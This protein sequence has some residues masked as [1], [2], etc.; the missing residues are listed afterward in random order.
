MSLPVTEGT[1]YRIAVD[2]FD[3]AM[4]NITL[5]TGVPGA[6]VANAGPDASAAA[7]AAFFLDARNSTDPQ[8]NPL[9]F[10]WTRLSGPAVVIETPNVGRTRVSGNH[11]DGTV[12]TF[13]VTVSDN[14]G[15]RDSDTVTI[16]TGSSK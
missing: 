14:A 11:A 13:R 3:G 16:T 5:H 12:M 7:N 4:G 15:N 1:T 10:A 2:G 6:P 8:G 9:T